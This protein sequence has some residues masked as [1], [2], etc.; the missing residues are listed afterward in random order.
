MGYE[1]LRLLQFVELNLTGLRKILKKF[2][3]NLGV[4]VM[5]QY[6]SSRGQGPYSQLQQLFGTAVSQPR[7]RKSH[8]ND[9][10]PLNTPLMKYAAYLKFFL[11]Q[12]R[13]LTQSGVLAVAT[14]V[15][16]QR[17]V[18]IQWHFTNSASADLSKHSLSL[19]FEWLFFAV[20]LSFTNFIAG[21]V[22]RIG[23]LVLGN[24]LM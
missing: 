15:Q 5:E 21:F 8:C 10:N 4:R 14:A 7:K 13:R 24:K 6:V 9:E 3:K 23:I 16:E 19:L 18:S 11:L 12:V 20:E 2:E 17:A 22:Q 1:L